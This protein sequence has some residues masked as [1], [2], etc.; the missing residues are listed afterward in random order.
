MKII[1]G[2]RPKGKTTPQLLPEYEKTRDWVAQR[3]F[4]G[5]KNTFSVSKNSVQFFNKGKPFKKYKISNN[6][7]K[8][9]LNLD[10]VKK[11]KSNQICWFDSE[12]LD[13]RVPDT[14]VIYDVLQWRGEYLTGISQINR[15]E[16]LKEVLPAKE[17]CDLGVA[18]KVTENIW[19]AEHFEDS[20]KK[21]YEEYLHLDLIEGLV[22]RSKSDYLRELGHRRY[23][24]DSQIRCRKPATNYRF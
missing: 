3:K 10:F 1:H 21:R 14:I 7:K 4:N 22:L 16:L 2:P 15:L 5:C 23:V 20:F 9:I 12:L 8:Q 19:L 24:T 17:T 11:M 18:L 13:P 6:L